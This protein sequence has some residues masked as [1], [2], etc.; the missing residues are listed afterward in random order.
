MKSF[1]R[2]LIIFS[3]TLILFVLSPL[4]LNLGNLSTR[5]NGFRFFAST[6]NAQ[7]SSTSESTQGLQDLAR[8]IKIILEPT[9]FGR[10]KIDID[11]YL[12]QSIES[13]NFQA[14]LSNSDNVVS[15]NSEYLAATVPD[16]FSVYLNTSSLD[17]QNSIFLIDSISFNDV[18]PEIIISEDRAFVRFRASSTSSN[19]NVVSDSGLQPSRLSVS[20]PQDFFEQNGS[21]TLILEVIDLQL[22]HL[23]SVPNQLEGNKATWVEFSNQT[24]EGELKLG[25]GFSKLSSLSKNGSYN[26]NEGFFYSI[27]KKITDILSI[28]ESYI[29]NRSYWVERNLYQFRGLVRVVP[30]IVA[31]LFYSF[32]LSKRGMKWKIKKPISDFIEKN[33]IFL[34]AFIILSATLGFMVSPANDRLSIPYFGWE[35]L[36]LTPCALL[37]LAV[38]FDVPLWLSK[39]IIVRHPRRLSVGLKHF[40]QSLFNAS[41]MLI[42]VII[43][44]FIY[45]LGSGFVWHSISYDLGDGFFRFLTGIGLPEGLSNFLTVIFF[46]LTP[47]LAVFSILALLIK[48]FGRKFLNYLEIINLPISR[49]ILALF[50]ILFVLLYTIHA[51]S[52][53][54][55]YYW[56]D[57]SSFIEFFASVLDDISDHIFYFVRLWY[58]IPLIGICLYL[59]R[60]SESGNEKT[61][62]SNILVA[63]AGKFIFCVYIIGTDNYAFIP[64]PFL[65]SLYLY[66]K[67]VLED[68]Q[69]RIFLG[70]V[71]R[72]FKEQTLFLRRAF[73]ATG[74][75][76]LPDLF[77]PVREK[78]L[79]GEISLREYKSKQRNLKS[80][81]VQECL[82]GK[83]SLSGDY[84]AKISVQ[85]LCVNTQ[86]NIERWE[87]GLKFSKYGLLIAHFYVAFY[88]YGILTNSPVEFFDGSFFSENTYE[89]FYFLVFRVGINAVLFYLRWLASAFFFGYFFID[90]RGDS[91]LKKG[92]RIALVVIACDLP[93]W[94]LQILVSN[95]YLSNGYF[96][97]I[98]VTLS[99][100]LLFFTLL[101]ILCFDWPLL[102][103]SL[104]SKFNL[105][106][107]LFFEDIPSIATFASTLLISFSTVF[108][109]VATDY[110]QSFFLD[111]LTQSQPKNGQTTNSQAQSE[112]GQDET[113]QLESESEE[114]Q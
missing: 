7:D 93:L 4:S 71:S 32:H 26:E 77:Q 97:Q 85:E 57:D 11:L 22:E 17:E 44:T 64:I 109:A 16:G 34:T 83:I 81:L 50:C 3:I 61:L 41:M 107:F 103:N 14:F 18:K 99:Q 10:L 111:V 101:G 8:E 76:K 12:S 89:A 39:K 65:M 54:P 114:S 47:F 69:K 94:L 92:V 75:S 60:R 108:S 55:S 43:L 46:V 110:F 35:I 105:D 88:I 104:R 36:L 28:R 21:D 45:I 15:K 91:G 102:K 86:T 95:I 66:P 53:Y 25:I 19:T 13:K 5:I 67:F 20:L 52:I 79:L 59:F 84:D 74:D 23:S 112:L 1:R 9:D 31:A 24:N 87:N 2:L 96:S 42:L 6:A 90:I 62:K 49:K 48:W 113:T 37:L 70:K 38:V 82:D 40:S 56:D 68:F 33:L 51:V 27:R 80:I 29:S 73:Y 78:F 58:Y 106:S 30:I 63:L 72:F 100:E 98:L